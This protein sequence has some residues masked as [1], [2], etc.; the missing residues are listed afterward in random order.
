MDWSS[1]DIGLEC[2]SPHFVMFFGNKT[3]SLEKI[4]DRFSNLDFRFLKQVHGDLCV[5]S[6]E[7]EVEADAHITEEKNLA[8]CIRTADCSPVLIASPQKI[9]AI[10]AGW[11]GVMAEILPKSLDAH[12]NPIP[13]NMSIAIGPHIQK[14][15]FQVDL[16]LGEAFSKKFGHEFVFQKEKFPGKAYVDLEAILSSALDDKIQNRWVSADDTLSTDHYYSHRREP[17]NKGRNISFV[18]RL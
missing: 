7:S 6:T 12:F 8:L 13:E 16:S 1:L 14:D 18:A 17:T 10:H 4:R 11:R 2:R 3:G 5:E 15:S 9:C